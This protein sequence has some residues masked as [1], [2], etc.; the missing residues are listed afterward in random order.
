MCRAADA[1]EE[2]AE[3][4]RGQGCARKIERML[5]ARRLRQG[6]QADPDRDRAKGNI[7]REQPRPRSD[8]KDRRSNRRPEREG[9][10]HYQRVV[11]EAAAQH[12][13]RVDEADQRR[14]DAHD[15]ACAQP[16]QRPSRRQAWQRPRERAA[17]R[18][19]REQQQA[20]KVDPAMSDDFAER[21]EWQQ[22]RHQRDLVDID[23]PDHLGRADL[24]VS[25]DGRQRD[26]R[27]RRIQRGHRQRG[28]DRRDRPAP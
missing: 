3:A 1:D 28:K 6:L 15:A 14:I 23:D 16:L 26:V 5:R 2:E 24:Q 21:A 8:R 18:G 13:G 19:Q 22:R 4:A 11:A 12:M 25:G 17:K 10:P 20:A 27:N 9:R 7:D